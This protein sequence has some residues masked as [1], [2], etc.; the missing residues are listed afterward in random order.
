VKP[1][2]RICGQGRHELHSIMTDPHVYQRIPDNVSSQAASF[3]TMAAISLRGI[4]V[5]RIELAES[6]IVQGLGLI[7]QMAVPLAKLAGARP[8]I[9][10]D[11]DPFRLQK[12]KVRGLDV[13]INP[14]EEKD[15]AAAIREHCP[16]DGA[17]V[18][19]ECTGKPAVYPQA[20]KLMAYNGRIVALGNP[21]GKVEMDLDYD[22]MRREIKILGAPQPQTPNAYHIYYPWTRK[23]ERSLIMSLMSDGTLTTEDLISR[24]SRPQD[25]QQVYTMLADQPRETLG[26]TFDW[27]A[28]GK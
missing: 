14:R 8:L 1:G 7:G 20:V 19:I 23:R 24:I 13:L 21:R 11:V 5:A 4:R 16:E 12:A 17:N 6:V 25:C 18:M 10:I 9:G 2:D 3:M 27:T 15:L 26:V 28:M 22:I